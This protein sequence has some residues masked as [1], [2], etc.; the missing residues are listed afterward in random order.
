MTY[1]LSSLRSRLLGSILT[2]MLTAFGVAMALIILLFVNHVQTRVLHDAQNVDIVVSGKGSPLQI[3]L[4]SIYHIDTPTGNIPWGEA[5]MLMN[6]PQIK[7]SAPL[8][9]GDNWNGHRIVGTT[10]DYI[11]FYQTKLTEGRLWSQPFQA[12]IGA[13]VDLNMGNTF[14]GAHGLEHSGHAHDENENKYVVVGKLEYTGTVLDR[15]ILTSLDSVL[16]MHGFE[17]IEFHDDHEEKH[18][19][20]SHHSHEGHAHGGEE[21]HKK[22]N[23]PEVTALLL[24]TKT[25][26]ANMRLPRI[27]NSNSNLQAANPAI[28]MAR[29]TSMLG[30]GTK[31]MA[32]VSM[33][34]L[35]I[36]CFS[37]FSGIAGTLE[38]RKTDLAIL[39]A[40]GYSRYRIFKIV[41]GEGVLLTLIGMSLG[42][43]LSFVGFEYLTQVVSSLSGSGATYHFIPE[44]LY[45]YGGALLAGLFASLIP[46]YRTGKIDVAKQLS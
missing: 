16:E 2:V 1:I 22:L 41:A 46:A 3:I 24:Q 36:A 7:K 19:D 11:D 10:P 23:E 32:A 13:D 35:T 39:R 38:N 5:K 34:L 15:L 37:I 4:S 42:G 26:L 27:I 45:I 28:E 9:L 25:P 31:T 29:L 14:A 6:H 30:I 43:L 18:D 12:I 17:N 33:T 8:A 40:F 20:H 21:D 44:M